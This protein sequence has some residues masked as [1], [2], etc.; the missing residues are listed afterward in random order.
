VRGN[1]PVEVER[2]LDG[3]GRAARMVCRVEVPGGGGTGF[4]IGPDLVLTSLHV[5]EG[6]LRGDDPRCARLVFVAR[7]S[8]LH[9]EWLADWSESCDAAVLRCAA[10]FADEWVEIPDLAPELKNGTFLFIVHHPP[11]GT[12]MSPA[13]VLEA[14]DTAVH[15]N[16]NTFNGS[17]GSPCFDVHLRL[18]AM[19]RAVNGGVPIGRIRDA[20]R[21]SLARSPSALHC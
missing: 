9:A 5:V 13:H 11:S 14:D 3:L 19:H 7:R 6:L 21:L 8:A 15:Y 4:V 20:L 16:A 1:G 12:L 10:P 17:S 2:W 18:A